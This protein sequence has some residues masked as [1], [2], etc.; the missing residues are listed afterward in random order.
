MKQFQHIL[1]VINDCSDDF[2][3]ESAPAVVLTKA[4]R[5]AADKANT[6]LHL[7]CVT[8]QKY[9]D[10][11]HIGLAFDQVEKRRE[12]CDVLTSKMD[13]LLKALATEGYAATGEVVWGYPR[14]QVVLDRINQ[15]NP[16]I[17]V[18]AARGY[19]AIE[20]YHLT[21]DAWQ[22]VR[23]CPKPLLLVKNSEWQDKPTLLAAVDPV[24]SHDKPQALDKRILDTALAT[25][26]QLAGELH[27]LHAYADAARPF[28]PAGV[29]QR[30]HRAALDKLLANYSIPANRVHFV[31]ETPVY[32][33]EHQINHLPVDVVVMG[34]LSR[35]RL[36]EM[37]VGSTAEQALDFYKVDILV[38]K[39]ARSTK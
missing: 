15:T 38:V 39:P 31:D 19:G 25:T 16:D 32:A 35:S 18:Q 27:V 28:A 17:V 8:Y 10:H 21:N 24:H 6:K 22:L 37:L 23:Q 30:E 5:L 34:A 26:Q 3:S 9:L 2:N 12:H 14:Y 29:V 4:K 20:L 13:A 7:L 11:D 33:I 36:Y 1:V